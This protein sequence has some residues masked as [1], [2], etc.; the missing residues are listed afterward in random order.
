MDKEVEAYSYS[1][2]LFNKKKE[3]AT[4]M[5][6]NMAD[7]RN[8]IQSEW[9]LA[10][11]HTEW[12]HL[13]EILENAKIIYGQKNHKSGR[14]DWQGMERAF[15]VDNNILFTD[16]DLGSLVYALVKTQ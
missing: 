9:S 11:V 2:T 12:F 15:W 13:Y 14:V 3:Q 10:W 6:N 4:V 7:L 1:V 8:I 5:L 16:R